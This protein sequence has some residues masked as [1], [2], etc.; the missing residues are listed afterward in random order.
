MPA[1]LR[2]AAGL[3]GPPAEKGCGEVAAAGAHVDAPLE[4]ERAIVNLVECARA[5][6]DEERAPAVARHSP[7]LGDASGQ[8]KGVAQLERAWVANKDHTLPP[9]RRKRVRSE[10]A[11]AH[12]AGEMPQ[13]WA[14]GKP[15]AAPAPH[16]S[17]PSRGSFGRLAQ[18]FFA[19]E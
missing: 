11:G 4:A 2:D 12:R 1:G 17:L 14:A 13:V 6:G 3:A 8:R 5:V 9:E 15:C 18:L 16:P 10:G 19:P 7:A